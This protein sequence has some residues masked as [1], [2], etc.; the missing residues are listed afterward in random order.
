MLTLTGKVDECK[1][2]MDGG[3]GDERTIQRRIAGMGLHS[4]TSH[5]DLSRFCRSKCSLNTPHTHIL[6]PA[7]ASTRPTENT[8]QSP[9]NYPLDPPYFTKGANI[10]LE[11]GRV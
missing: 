2:L 5:L 8:P 11:S 6:T 10:E 4:S 1:P 7:T 9:P 3:Y